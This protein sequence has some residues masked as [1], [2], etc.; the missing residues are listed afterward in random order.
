METAVEFDSEKFAPFLPDGA[1]ARPLLLALRGLL[2]EAS[3]ISN[4]RWS[5]EKYGP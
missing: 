1:H 3:E 5:A 2:D 4:V